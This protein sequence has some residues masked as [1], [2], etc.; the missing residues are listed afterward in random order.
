MTGDSG[1][2]FVEV[3]AREV[4]ADPGNLALREDFITLLLEHDTGRAATELKAFEASGG[5]PVR[6]RVLRARLSRRT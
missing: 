3:I 2:D 6:A 4:E 5:D 1:D